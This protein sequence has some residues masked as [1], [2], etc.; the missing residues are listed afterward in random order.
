MKQ[1]NNKKGSK[2]IKDNESKAGVN[3]IALKTPKDMLRDMPRIFNEL[4]NGNMDID[5]YGFIFVSPQFIQA[6]T[7]YCQEQLAILNSLYRAYSA[8]YN[9]GTMLQNEIDIYNTI[10]TKINMYQYIYNIICIVDRDK[11]YQPMKKLQYDLSTN[12][13]NFIQ[14]GVSI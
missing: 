1:Q 4:G 6:G 10:I 3:F 5:K 12:Y 13:R 7:Q 11:S 2:Y 8:L 9:S 14:R